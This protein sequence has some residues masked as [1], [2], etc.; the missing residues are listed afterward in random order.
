[1]KLC[2]CGCGQ[3]APIA[4][5]T[6]ARHGWV[7]GQPLRFVR[8]HA[9]RRNIPDFIEVDRGWATPCWIWQR[10]LSKGGYGMTGTGANAHVV[11][12]RRYRF[13]P[14]PGIQLDHLCRQTDCVQPYHLEPVTPRVNLH[15]S[16]V[17][18]LMNGVAA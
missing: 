12:F 15:R 11:Y 14:A 3:P 16:S 18:D 10:G 13:V 1:M 4:T 5:R 2:D 17:C 6:D 8:G 7:K 9:T